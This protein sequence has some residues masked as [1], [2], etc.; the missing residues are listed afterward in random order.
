[1]AKSASTSQAAGGGHPPQAPAAT[2]PPATAAPPAAASQADPGGYKLPAALARL[3]GADLLLE[4]CNVFAVDPDQDVRPVELD[5]WKFYPGN[6]L[7]GRP[8]QVV[9]VT[10]GGMKIGWFR[11][12]DHPDQALLVTHG[13]Q[14]DQATETRLRPIFGA[15]QTDPKTKDVTPIPLPDDLALPA[16]VVTGLSDAQAHV[17]KKGYLQSGGK[18][19]AD[20]RAQNRSG[21]GRK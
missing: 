6:R 2:P 14:F 4:A 19:E 12:P 16:A 8:D 7:E 9:L 5:N 11:T 13:A 10:R 20:R 3:A 21:R 15:W 18:Q 17:Y 1:M